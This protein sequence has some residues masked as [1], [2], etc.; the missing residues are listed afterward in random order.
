M[1]GMNIK[2]HC[3]TFT[4]LLTNRSGNVYLTDIGNNQWFLVRV[5]HMKN[6]PVIHQDLPYT[7]MHSNKA[8]STIQQVCCSFV[9]VVCLSIGAFRTNCLTAGAPNAIPPLTC[10]CMLEITY[11]M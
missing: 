8:I 4:V 5:Q 9:Y 10:I 2:L 11:K 6:S 7:V 1:H 3:Y